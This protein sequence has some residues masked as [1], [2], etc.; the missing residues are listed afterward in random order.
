MFSLISKDKK[1]S[2]DNRSRIMIAT[3]RSM[4][5]ESIMCWRK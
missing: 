3:M 2:S 1:Q 4:V 5:A